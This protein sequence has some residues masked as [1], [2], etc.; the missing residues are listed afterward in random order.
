MTQPEQ[1]EERQLADAPTAGPVRGQNADNPP[2]EP[3]VDDPDAAADSGAAS[4]GG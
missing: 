3:S 2:S 1:S 4:G